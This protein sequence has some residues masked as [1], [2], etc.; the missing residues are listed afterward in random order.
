VL[1]A[2]TDRKRHM[3]IA[4]VSHRT[5]I[6]RATVR[7]SL[8]TLER[9]GY[10]LED[11][12]RRYFL[13]PKVLTFGHAYLSATPLALLAQPVL[14]RLSER[15]GESSSLAVV[16]GDEIIYVARSTSS[17]ILS[18]ALNVGR[19]LPAHCTSI[20][21]IVLSHL[22]DADLD[23]YLG[24]VQF[25]PFTPQTVTSRDELRRILKAARQSG[26]AS[27]DQQMEPHFRTLAV[28]VRNM[29]GVVVGG[30]NVIIENE[31]MTIAQMASQFVK[32]LQHAAAEL[33]VG[34]LP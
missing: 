22:P 6:P 3:S 19:R 11:D 8:H 23:A 28:P 31:R 12:T 16:E 9:L 5:G 33:S 24:R 18:P 15:I 7:R 14:D 1:H 21:R 32:P 4:D 20:G 17:R 29:H 25:R 26:Y 27:A 13:R 2:F 30:I 34:L 10:V